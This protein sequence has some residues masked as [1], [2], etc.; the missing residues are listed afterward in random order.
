MYYTSSIWTS[1]FIP[2]TYSFN[3]HTSVLNFNLGMSMSLISQ[4]HSMGVQWLL[5]IPYRSVKRAALT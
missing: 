4:Y 5:W 1:I 3:N 2:F